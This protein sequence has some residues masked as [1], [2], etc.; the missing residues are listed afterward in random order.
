MGIGR[1]KGVFLMYYIDTNVIV[2]ATRNKK[3]SARI[4]E[5][6]RSVAVFDICI[7]S[8]V[9][10][11]LEF[12]ARHSN[13]YEQNI[14]IIR[15]FISPYKIIPFT[16][17]EAVEYGKIR[18]FLTTEGQPIGP[19]DML[20]AATALANDAVLVTHNTGEFERVPNIRLEDW[21]L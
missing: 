14:K 17:K 15:Q 16:E 20:I 19:N 8:I 12:G 11:E 3:V 2:D 5:H 6:F 13:S 9:L 7:P 21:T 1:K 18:Q 4:L 10:S